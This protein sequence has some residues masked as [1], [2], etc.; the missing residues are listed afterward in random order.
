MNKINYKESIDLNSK[1]DELLLINIDENLLTNSDDNFVNIEGEI[2][3][4][5][6]VKTNDEQKSFTHSINVNISLSK[7]QLSREDINISIDDFNYTINNNLIEIDLYLKID[8]LKEIDACFP[9][10]EDK[11]N[12]EIELD[13]DNVFDNK[14]DM[15]EFREVSDEKAKKFAD[16]N[17]FLFSKISAKTNTGLNEL[18][19]SI[20]KKILMD[21]DP[22]AKEQE[23]IEKGKR[24]NESKLLNDSQINVKKGGCC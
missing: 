9:S 24:S 19:V 21:D 12:V 8:G 13:D 3:I 11:E 22:Q 16:T 18:F 1:I 7:E 20:A 15:E 14:I 4:S 6:E 17:D 5:G 23:L 10:Q 2:K